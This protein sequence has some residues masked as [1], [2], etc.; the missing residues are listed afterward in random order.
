MTSQ[1]ASGIG[2]AVK[3]MVKGNLPEEVTSERRPEWM[4]EGVLQADSTA[5]TKALR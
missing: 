4:K 5:C 3:R 1:R 2:V